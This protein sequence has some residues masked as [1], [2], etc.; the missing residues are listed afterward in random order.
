M[1]FRIISIDT[2]TLQV[3]VDFGDQITNITVGREMLF[4]DKATKEG[5]MD[6]IEIN[7]PTPKVVESLSS[8]IMELVDEHGAEVG[9][10]LPFKHTEVNTNATV[11]SVFTNAEEEIQTEVKSF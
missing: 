5:L 10:C 1:N 3:T 7:R 6:Y 11:E 9:E 8:S 2:E 4:G